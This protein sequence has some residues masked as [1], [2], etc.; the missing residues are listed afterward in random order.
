MISLCVPESYVERET[1]MSTICGSE[2]VEEPFKKARARVEY[3]TPKV[4]LKKEE[5]KEEVKAD[6]VKEEPK[7][8]EKEEVK[9]TE[10]VEEP[11][12]E[13]VSEEEKKS[14]PQ[15]NE[16]TDGKEPSASLKP[17]EDTITM[18]NRK[19]CPVKIVPTSTKSKVD[20]KS[21][22]KTT[23]ED[24]GINAFKVF[25]EKEG[26]RYSNIKRVNTGLVELILPNSTILS[27]DIN[28]R[29][30]GVGRPVA[31]IGKLKPLDEYKPNRKG[32]I[33]NKE[34]VEAIKKGQIPA[35]E[36]L[37]TEEKELIYSE[38]DINSLT[39]SDFAK[40]VKVIN[41]AHDSIKLHEQGIQEAAAGTPVRFTFSEYKSIDD[42][43]LISSSISKISALCNDNLRTDK[44]IV[45]QIKGKEVSLIH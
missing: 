39:E 8:D 38:L 36:Y 17:A 2:K 19:V 9:E 31:F 35:E 22:G 13:E 25:L 29:L 4:D 6:P 20:V 15:E 16:T 32:F 23:T 27:V 40:R 1:I 18:E 28:D 45:I 21:A 37:I 26:I 10:K 33:L 30:Y 5:K 24:E 41:K 7:K 12:K 34:T 11:V 14:Y 44:T 3:I 42:F 43:K